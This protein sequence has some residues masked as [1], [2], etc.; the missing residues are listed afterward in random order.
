MPHE[1]ERKF[2][3]N[4]ERLPPLPEGT[5]IRQGY[6]PA[7]CGT[8]RVRIAGPEAFLTIKGPTEGLSRLEFEYPIPAEEARR[9][10]DD[11]CDPA[12]IDKTRH[13]IEF[14]G[15]LWELDVFHGANEGLLLAE[16]ELKREDEHVDLPPWAAD[17]VS[18]DSRYQNSNLA[19]KPFPTWNDG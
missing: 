14:A 8:V 9:M 12:Q 18:H 1:I 11:L 15:H 4:P 13:R 16:V 10:L 7:I 19:R 6:L 17:E 2:L 5:P 3:V